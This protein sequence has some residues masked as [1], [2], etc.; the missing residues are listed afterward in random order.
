MPSAT[1][2]LRLQP[3]ASQVLPQVLLLSDA[4]SRNVQN[5]FYYSK[6]TECTVTLTHAAI[7]R[8]SMC[9]LTS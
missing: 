3:L 6:V 9:V 4:E 8:V 7:S 1:A 2:L 5:C